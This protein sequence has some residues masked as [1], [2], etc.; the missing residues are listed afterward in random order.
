MQASAMGPTRSSSA[1]KSEKQV[2][3]GREAIKGKID[4]T[5]E[6]QCMGEGDI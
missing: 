4:T 1:R 6:K 3:R 5:N 2:I